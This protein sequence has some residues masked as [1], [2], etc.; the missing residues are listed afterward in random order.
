M[1]QSILRTLA[2]FD[3]ADYPLTKEELFSYLWQS[4][5]V[6]LRRFLDFLN[7]QN[8]IQEKIWLLFFTRPRG[9][10]R[11]ASRKAANQ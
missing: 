2:Y 4:P 6:S 7:D 10:S 8:I 3:L 9:H 11:E 1:E 5:A